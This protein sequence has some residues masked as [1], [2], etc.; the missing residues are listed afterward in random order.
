MENL[1]F[2]ARKAF[3]KEENT[4]YYTDA[5]EYTKVRILDE[6]DTRLAKNATV[7]YGEVHVTSRV[8]GFKKIKFGTNE[9]VG[10]GDIT[11]PENEMHTTK[12]IGL[13]SRRNMLDAI[14]YNRAEIIDGLIG[15]G[16][17]LH[18]LCVR[19]PYV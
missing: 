15:V 2:A 7:E 3:V 1:D 14:S 5:M 12:T 16:Y 9:N 19:N 6:F 8:V 13:Q 10:F 11:L 4:D 18:N 17:I